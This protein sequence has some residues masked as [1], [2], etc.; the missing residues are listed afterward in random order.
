MFMVNHLV[1]FGVGSSVVPYSVQGGADT[2]SDS[3]GYTLVDRSFAVANSVTITTMGLY[4]TTGARTV[5]LKIALENSSTNHDIVKSESFSHTGSGWEDFTLSSAY[6]IPGSGTY[7]LAAYWTGTL[8]H[9]GSSLRSY[10]AGDA[11]GTGVGTTAD[12]NVMAV[13]RAS[14]YYT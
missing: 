11:T 6:A 14:G 13:L 5:T 4:N 9:R 1:G 3:G 7:R 10:V 2:T 12:T 8:R